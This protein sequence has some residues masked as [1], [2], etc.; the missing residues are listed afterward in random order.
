M[1]FGLALLRKPDFFYFSLKKETNTLTFLIKS[2]RSALGHFFFCYVKL[3]QGFGGLG[4]PKHRGPKEGSLA[5]GGG[6]GKRRGP[7][8]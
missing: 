1:C 2:K 3:G 4:D 6:H 5:S 8:Y 7:S